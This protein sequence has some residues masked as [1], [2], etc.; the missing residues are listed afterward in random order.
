MDWNSSNSFWHSEH[1]YWYVGILRLYNV[2]LPVILTF[3]RVEQSSAAIVRWLLIRI[4]SRG[5]VS[6]WDLA[7]NLSALQPV[8]P[9][10]EAALAA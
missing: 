7:S 5:R 9:Y 10:E 6:I 4:A 2:L 1:R 8:H 3:Y